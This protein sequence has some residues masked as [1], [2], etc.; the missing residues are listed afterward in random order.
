MVQ[1]NAFQ[2]IQTRKVIVYRRDCNSWIKLKRTVI[3]RKWIEVQLEWVLYCRPILED[4]A[5][6]RNYRSIEM[7]GQQLRRSGKQNLT[8]FAAFLV[9]ATQIRLQAFEILSFPNINTV[10]TFA[11]TQVLKFGKFFQALLKI[12]AGL[13]ISIVN[14]R[15]QTSFAGIV[16]HVAISWV[17]ACAVWQSIQ[18]KRLAKRPWNGSVELLFMGENVRA[19]NKPSRPC[20]RAAKA[21]ASIV[22]QSFSRFSNKT[23]RN[24]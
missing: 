5:T 23:R 1:Y 3:C 24:S 21:S 18:P 12:L 13:P 7:N 22:R 20:G 6:R 14:K 15:A 2:T 9:I 19:F 17:I 16:M 4:K 10:I 8:S 11:R